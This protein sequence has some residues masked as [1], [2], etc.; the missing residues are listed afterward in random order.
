M[1]QISKRVDI[2]KRA[3]MA[4]GWWISPNGEIFSIEDEGHGDFISAHPELFGKLNDSDKSGYRSIALNNGWIRVV[5]GSDSLSFQPPSSDKKYMVTIQ[6]VLDK[7]PIV[8]T[9][10]VDAGKY[11]LAAPFWDFVS[12]DSFDELSKYEAASSVPNKTAKVVSDKPAYTEKETSESGGTIYRY[13]PE[14]IDA[15]WKDKVSKL[16]LLEKNI[17][18]LRTQYNKDLSSEDLRTRAEAAVVGILDDTSQ[19]IGNEESVKEYKTYGVSTFKVKH[20]TF[21]GS[22][23]TFKFVGKDQVK[24]DVETSNSK[25]TSVLKELVKGKKDDDFVFEIDGTKIWDRAINRYLEK[26]DISAK[27]LRGFQANRIMKEKLKKKDFKEALEETAKEV[28]HE[29]ATLK[30]QYLD[31][32]LVK[33]YIKK[34]SISV[35]ALDFLP[36]RGSPQDITDNEQQMS[37]EPVD[38]NLNVSNILP[39]VR[40][41]ASVDLMRAWRVI[42]PFLS[43]GATLTSAYRTRFDQAKTILEFWRAIRWDGGKSVRWNG[44]FFH[45]FN[46]KVGTSQRELDYLYEKASKQLLSRKDVGRINT[47]QNFMFKYKP[48]TSSPLKGEPPGGVQVAPVDLSEHR[49]GIAM[50]IAKTDLNDVNKAL[51]FLKVK[52]PGSVVLAKEPFVENVNQAI[53]IEFAGTVNMPD[54][55]TFINLIRELKQT[56]IKKSI[57]RNHIEKISKL[58]PEDAR[59]IESIRPRS[60]TTTPAT[61]MSKQLKIGPNAKLNQLMYD[62]WRSLIPFLPNGATITSG[63]RTPQDQER[64]L[65]NYWS[66]SGLTAQ[67]KGYGDYYAMSKIL[68][69]RGYVVGP[70]STNAQYGHLKGNAIDISGAN[71]YEIANAIKMVSDHP[72]IPIQFTQPLVE[73]KNNDVHVGI[74]SAKYDPIAI[75]KVLKERSVSRIASAHVEYKMAS[76]SFTRQDLEKIYELEYKISILTQ[77]DYFGPRLNYMEK[78]LGELLFNGLFSIKKGYE[79]RLG[80]WKDNYKNLYDDFLVEMPD[81]PEEEIHRKVFDIVYGRSA[82]FQRLD[83]IYNEL[84]KSPT[85]NIKKDSELFNRA[86]NA[87]HY[88]G[89]MVEYLSWELEDIDG[90]LLDDLTSGEKYIPKWN[91]ELDKIVAEKNI[92]MRKLSTR[93][94]DNIIKEDFIPHGVVEILKEISDNVYSIR[95]DSLSG[96]INVSKEPVVNIKWYFVVNKD[97]PK[98][99][100]SKYQAYVI[101]EERFEGFVERNTIFDM[102]GADALELAKKMRESVTG[103]EFQKGFLDGLVENYQKEQVEKRD[104][105]RL[106]VENINQLSKMAEDEGTKSVIEDLMRS[107]TPKEVKEEFAQHSDDEKISEQSNVEDNYKW[108]EK[109]AFSAEM[110]HDGAPETARLFADRVMKEHFNEWVEKGADRQLWIDH[111]NAL[112]SM[113]NDW[114]LTHPTPSPLN[115]LM[116][117]KPYW[118]ARYDDEEGLWKEKKAGLSIRAD[119]KIKIEPTE[120]EKKIF[121]LLKEVKEYYKLPVELRVVGGWVRDSIL[122]QMEKK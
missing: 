46:N 74:M 15:R 80:Q 48:N 10:Y 75:A 86:L 83:S 69:Q 65:R 55:N 33:K 54:I 105:K 28:G 97:E 23:T 7:L 95:D 104:I 30:N 37:Q 51:Q 67:D 92:L 106:N 109:Q 116:V 72:D 112:Q 27:D 118:W 87:A 38:P 122:K 29:P 63:V 93:R 59:W 102:P 81:A 14:H 32:A 26:F 114:R 120:E 3:N 70:P 52:L 103:Q 18:R 71:L 47:L 49:F 40:Q 9:V 79:K 111:I 42:A 73:E 2:K 119:D 89:K 16:K 64:I 24:Q 35:R 20:L 100:P 39:K 96:E 76:N 13:N 61:T 21:S 108:A 107:N 36:F 115:G 94:D 101:K 98:H 58:T 85:G 6:K 60:I 19:R 34:A 84:L 45:N 44:F 4:Y 66:I 77:R 90:S 117:R 43:P 110:Q 31:P 68:G 41:E 12:C 53:H 8:K 82:T 25:I 17:E 1:N 56:N 50:D 5:G 91:K 88:N 11:H 113:I 62:A 22:K 99:S 78:L 57:S 121:A